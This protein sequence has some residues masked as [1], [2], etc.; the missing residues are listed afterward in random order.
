MRPSLWCNFLYCRTC[1]N[2]GNGP[3]RSGLRRPIKLR[4]P[5]IGPA[6]WTP[7]FCTRCGAGCIRVV[8]MAVF[9]SIFTG[10][11]PLMEMIAQLIQVR[12]RT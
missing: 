1:R 8:V 4:R 11:K 5:P 6:A 3:R 2:A 7:C 9:Q 12:A 10:A